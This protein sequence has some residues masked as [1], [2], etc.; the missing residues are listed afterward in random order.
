MNFSEISISTKK[1]SHDSNSDDTKKFE[2]KN[3]FKKEFILYISSHKRSNSLFSLNF[4]NKEGYFLL[5][6]KSKGTIEKILHDKKIKKKFLN[7]DVDMKKKDN[8]LYCEK[9]NIIDKYDKIVNNKININCH[10][11]NKEQIFNIYTKNDLNLSIS[12]GQI[13][14]KYSK[15]NF[16]NYIP[17]Q[18]EMNYKPSKKPNFFPIEVFFGINKFINEIGNKDYLCLKESIFS[19]ENDSYKTINKKEHYLLNHFLQKNTKTN[20]ITFRYRHKN[21]TFIYYK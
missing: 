9:S 1:D 7:F 16:C 14:F 6:R 18:K 15:K 13:D 3:S 2:T 10:I 5:F 12:N 20:S 21:A 19:K 11:N 4:R 17:K 8:K